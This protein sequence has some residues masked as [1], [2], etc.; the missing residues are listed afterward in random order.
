MKPSRSIARSWRAEPDA[1]TPDLAAAL[2]NQ[3]SRRF[4]VGDDLTGAM[5]ASGGSRRSLSQSCE[6]QPSR[7]HTRL[8]R[9]TWGWAQLL[10][11]NSASTVW[12]LSREAVN[13]LRLRS[14]ITAAAA[15]W[16]H[17]RGEAS[18]AASLLAAAAAEAATE[19]SELRL[20]VPPSAVSEARRAVRAAA[21]RIN[22]NCDG[23]PDWL[24][25]PIAEE[26]LKL[27]W[28]AATATDRLTLVQLV[29]DHNVFF[30]SSDFAM[31]LDTLNVLHPND[32]IVARLAFLHS[33]I[34][35]L[36]LDGALNR[37]EREDQLQSAIQEW[38][39]MPTWDDSFNYLADD[40][41]KFDTDET[42]QMLLNSGEP[43]A[44]QH[45][46]ILFLTRSGTMAENQGNCRSYRHR[47]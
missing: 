1:F 4:E 17:E 40:L 18:T 6:G 15:V 27:L 36:G 47:H 29:R 7:L 43:I 33:L 35:E 9:S 20:T 5:T 10:N 13:D 46:A 23:L 11:P 3:A 12:E 32:A 21:E 14:R 41:E 45:A 34:D 24:M 38:I 19:R 2:N 16:Y 26:E 22:P 28:D 42:V 25:R 30:T 44:F 37:L 39:A 8:Q 31:A